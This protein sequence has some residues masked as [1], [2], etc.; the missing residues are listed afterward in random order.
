MKTSGSL[1]AFTVLMA[2][3]ANGFC[4]SAGAM[5]K[6]KANVPA[7]TPTA[8]PKNQKTTTTTTTTS[9]FQKKSRFDR[10]LEKLFDDSDTNK[11]GTVSFS[12]TYELVLKM[13]VNINRQ[14]PIPP[15]TRKKVLQLYL[16]ADSSQNGRLD[17]E[18]FKGLAKTLGGR[19]ASRLVAHKMVTLIGAPLLAEYL[20]RTLA[21]KDWLIRTAEFVIPNRFHEK[22]LPVVCS[23]PFCRTVLMVLLVA[24]LGNIVL[25]IVNWV[26]DM[27]LPEEDEDPRLAKYKHV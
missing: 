7:T 1:L 14:A 9:L 10:F 23:K 13:Y 22:A 24:S 21:G 17:K 19:A 18:E 16:N 5:S 12:E 27:S 2:Q 3:C 15:P 25:S 20:V 4:A 8:N 6:K 26:M 11:D